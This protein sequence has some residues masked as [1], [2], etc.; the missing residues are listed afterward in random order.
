MPTK[1]IDEEL[2]KR[3]EEATVNVITKSQTL[4]KET[5]ILQFVIHKGLQE[6]S[7]EELLQYAVQK[8]IK[9]K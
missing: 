2:W 1:H 3:V 5:E 4:V 8:R 6:I 7:D 9:I